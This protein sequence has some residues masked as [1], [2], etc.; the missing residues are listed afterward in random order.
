M[1][2]CSKSSLSSASVPLLRCSARGFIWTDSAEATWC[3]STVRAIGLWWFRV[4]LNL[5]PALCTLSCANLVYPA[6]T[7]AAERPQPMNSG[8]WLANSER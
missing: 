7:W 1:C 8:L 4:T 3:S 5:S 6:K 2:V